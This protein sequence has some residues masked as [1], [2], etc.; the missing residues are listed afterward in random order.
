MWCKTRRRRH[1]PPTRWTRWQS[2]PTHAIGIPTTTRQAACR[3]LPRSSFQSALTAGALASARFAPSPSTR[4]ACCRCAA[5]TRSC[6]RPSCSRTTP[7][8]RDT[9]TTWADRRPT[10][11]ALP[12]TSSSSTVCARTSAA[13][14]RAYARTWWST[15]AATRSCCATC[16]SYRASR[17]SSSA[18]ASVLTTPWPM[19]RTS[20]CASCW[21]ITSRASCA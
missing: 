1:S 18:A 17:R 15:R 4:V 12:A 11:A 6:A 13:C 10:L 5:T 3:P 7:S 16:A 14:G 20:F 19:P 21:S 9:S 8:L 2:S